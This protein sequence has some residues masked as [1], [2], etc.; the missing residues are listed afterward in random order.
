MRPE[1]ALTSAM[2]RAKSVQPTFFYRK[3]S[4]INRGYKNLTNVISDTCRKYY[5]SYGR[6]QHLQLS[7]D[8]TKDR[9]CRDRISDPSEQHKIGILN[10]VRYEMMVQWFRKC[11]S[12]SERERHSSKGNSD[13]EFGIAFDQTRIDF[14]TNEEKE[15]T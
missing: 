7:Q 6:I 13:R 1:P 2:L 11:H 4:E 5:N 10:A 15:E 12:K 14:E 8:P 3:I 9:E